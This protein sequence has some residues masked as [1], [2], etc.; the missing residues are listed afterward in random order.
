MEQDFYRDEFEQMLRDTTEDFKMYPSRKVWYSIYNNFHP[1]R[2]W[3][4]LAICLLLLTA[5]LYIGVSN[6]NQISRKARTA[7]D[8]TTQSENNSPTTDNVAASDPGYSHSRSVRIAANNLPGLSNQGLTANPLIAVLNARESS[9]GG[10]VAFDAYIGMPAV[11][12]S[13]IVISSPAKRINDRNPGNLLSNSSAA[14][15]K[16]NATTITEDVQPSVPIPSLTETTAITAN[17]DASRKPGSIFNSTE[18]TNLMAWMENDA[19]YNLRHPG[20]WKAKLSVQYYITPSIGYRELYKSHD[21]EP[22]TS[23]VQST[24]VS[25]EEVINQQAAIN[26]EAGFGLV[27]RASK[28]LRLKSGLQFNVTNY[29]TRAHALKHP[30]QT[31]VMLADLNNGIAMPQAYSSEYGNVLGS[32]YTSLNN[33]TIQLSVPVGADYKILGN[34]KISWFVGATV[35]PTFIVGGDA[36]LIS[37]D[38]KNFAQDN[39]MLRSF[40]V[41]T[42]LESFISIKG[43]QNLQLSVGPQLRYQLLSTYTKQYSYTEKLYNL[44]LKL[45]ITRK[46]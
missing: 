15:A 44:G 37:T 4:S 17:A 33:R 12:N 19:F 40:N 32:N 24:N 41:N 28:S 11:T 35:Q 8:T 18:H 2:K 34:E 5:I 39:K 10:D 9:N 38:L 25:E 45:G 3:P 36:Y 27:L 23:L 31:S 13:D 29:V 46:L 26:L 21:F 14:T 6:N 16:I 42:A 20:K 1:D 22:A 43:P 30:T 7:F